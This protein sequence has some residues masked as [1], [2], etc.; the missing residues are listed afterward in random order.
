MKVPESFHHGADPFSGGVWTGAIGRL[1]A[2]SS[3][4]STPFS[5]CGPPTITFPPSFRRSSFSTGR[6]SH[7]KLDLPVPAV[8][9]SAV[10]TNSRP[11]EASPEGFVQGLVSRVRL[12]RS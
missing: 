12:R 6:Q 10:A 9:E 3:N 1:W 7:R 11:R 2:L 5:T 8:R 4:T